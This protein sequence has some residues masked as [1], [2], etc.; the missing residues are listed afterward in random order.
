MLKVAKIENKPEIFYSIQGEG[1]NLGKPSIFIR[2]SL[3][4]LSCIWCDTDYTWNW[5]NT[6]FKHQ[7][8]QNPN[9]QKY[10][11]KDYLVALSNQSLI[12]EIE[13]YPSLQIVITG[14]E[15]L[16]QQKKLISFISELKQKNPNYHI[17]FETNGTITPLPDLDAQA[18]QY[19]VSV[20]LSNA[21]V[22]E[23]ERIKPAALRFFAASQKAY[24]KFVIEKEQDLEEVFALQSTY[25][26]PKERIYLMPEGRQREILQKRQNW[27]IEICKKHL[28]N[29]TDRLHIHIYGDRR[30][31]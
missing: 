26:I 13:Q 17:E 6:T 25:Q 31:I 5:E 23:K 11:K 28:F 20:K 1:K 15:P 4:N 10:A 12:A 18:D 3:C 9:Y 30:G 19:N 29:Y 16:L 8:D 2:L 22:S 7:N 14:G 24:F 27:L 21:E